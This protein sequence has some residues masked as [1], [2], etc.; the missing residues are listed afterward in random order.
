LGIDL[1]GDLFSIRDKAS[2]RG[3]IFP[4]DFMRCSVASDTDNNRASSRA[5]IS[6]ESAA[7]STGGLA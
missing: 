1:A 5:S 4:A 2:S 7:S 6:S 3:P